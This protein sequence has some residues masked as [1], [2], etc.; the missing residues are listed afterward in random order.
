LG[1]LNIEVTNSQS[2]FGA[3]IFGMRSL[4]SLLF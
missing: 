3:I 4:K 1:I 2:M